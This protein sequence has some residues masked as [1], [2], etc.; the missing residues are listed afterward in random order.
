MAQ[1]WHYGGLI[2]Q[3]PRGGT[4]GLRTSGVRTVA[5]AG[6]TLYGLS[7]SATDRTDSIT[8]VNNGVYNAKIGDQMMSFGGASGGNTIN[9]RS[10]VYGWYRSLSMHFFSTAYDYSTAGSLQTKNLSG[11]FTGTYSYLDLKNCGS[12]HFAPDGSKIIFGITAAAPGDSSGSGHLISANLSTAFDIT[13]MSSSY[14]VKK[15]DTFIGDLPRFSPDGSHVF[16]DDGSPTYSTKEY[17]LSTPWDIST[18]TDTGSTIMPYYIGNNTY[19]FIGGYNMAC[20]ATGTQWLALVQNRTVSPY[21]Y[22]LIRGTASTAYR[23]N[24]ITWNLDSDAML[25]VQGL[26]TA[27]PTLTAS[28]DLTKVWVRE[29]NA[30]GSRTLRSITI[31]EDNKPTQRW[32]RQLGRSPF[33]G[34]ALRSTGIITTPEAYQLKL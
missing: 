20:D 1:G 13:T 21:E 19:N 9:G 10:A 4:G 16:Y 27:S 14:T 18:A 12:P 3:D 7:S 30:D 11:Y 32:G 25:Q 26:N 33:F 24:T 5:D 23:R 6:Q 29:P 2:G 31:A 8:T 22:H 17:E 28:P 34:T 15:L